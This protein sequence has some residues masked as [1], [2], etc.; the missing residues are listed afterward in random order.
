MRKSSRRNKI[1]YALLIILV[2]AFIWMIW[3][4]RPNV[5]GSSRTIGWRNTLLGNYAMTDIAIDANSTNYILLHSYGLVDLNPEWGMEW[6]RY[7]DAESF[8]C[9]LDSQLSFRDALRTCGRMDG[10]Y[11][12]ESFRGS[13]YCMGFNG[14]TL[15][16]GYYA[17]SLNNNREYDWRVNLPEGIGL[18]FVLAIDDE[19]NLY[20]MTA[21]STEYSSLVV[22][23][24]RSGELLWTKGITQEGWT[25]DYGLAVDSNGIVYAGL[26]TRYGSNSSVPQSP[27]RQINSAEGLIICALDPEGNEIER[28]YILSSLGFVMTD[29]IA[30]A[31]DE[32]DSIYLASSFKDDVTFYS[33]DAVPEFNLDSSTGL[34][35]FLAKWNSDFD[36]EWA[37]QW[38]GN[39]YVQPIKILSNGSGIMY[40][41]GKY[42]KNFEFVG[43]DD[44]IRLA[45]ETQDQNLFILGIGIDGSLTGFWSG[46]SVGRW[47]YLRGSH[48]MAYEYKYRVSW[49]AEINGMGDIVY[50]ANAWFGPY[51]AVIPKESIILEVPFGNDEI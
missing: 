34:S 29:G 3:P 12:I 11:L 26:K 44:V 39:G 17:A 18:E 25:D 42:T 7:S 47:G 46:S 48:H 8:L 22:K 14:P 50:C 19:G 4:L 21:S 16:N 6:S 41:C 10:I 51:L 32:D 35:G 31:V 36:F 43:N 27:E 13:F 40:V 45:T 9:R 30:L 2:L 20:V 5:P 37:G 28:K 38:R 1:I 23:I 49:D 33:E 15:A 24:S